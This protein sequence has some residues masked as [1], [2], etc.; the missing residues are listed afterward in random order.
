[1]LKANCP[2]CK[3]PLEIMFEYT[4][5]ELLVAIA[6]CENCLDNL[7]SDWKLIYNKNRE[8]DSIERYF[9]G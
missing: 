5:A 8:L 1:M 6:H 7:D 2:I 3:K 4:E 9:F